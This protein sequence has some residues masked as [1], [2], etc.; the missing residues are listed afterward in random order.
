[1]PDNPQILSV[2]TSINAQKFLEA[3]S[4]SDPKLL[5]KEARSRFGADAPLILQQLE[6]LQKAKTKAPELAAHGWLFTRQ[7]YEQASSAATAR[8]KQTLMGGKQLVDLTAGAGID[9]WYLSKLFEKTLLVEANEERAALLGHNFRQVAQVEV[10]HATAEE[11]ID[12]LE[13]NVTVYI[14]PDRRPGGQRVNGLEQSMPDILALLPQLRAKKS[15]VWIK[16]SPMLDISLLRNQLGSNTNI[17]CISVDQEMKELLLHPDGNGLLEAVRL[18][19][20]GQILHRYSEDA[21]ANTQAN[22][23]AD[24]QIGDWFVEPHV[25]LI[26]SRLAR[27][28]AAQQGWKA[29]N[30]VADYYFSAEA[31]SDA[32]GRW[33]RIEKLWPYKPK[34]LPVWLKE[35]GITKANIAKRD[36]FLD[37]AALRKVLRLADGGDDYLFFTKNKNGDPLVV[38]GRRSI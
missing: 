7:S 2:L 16:A 9:G 34:L 4:F 35:T 1:M 3:Y 12:R 13:E 27:K 38:H 22:L 5:Q 19:E 18:H 25:A 6:L 24:A 17:W 28:Y 20:N 23:V 36:F 8:F 15:D 32:E 11:Q 33:F 10:V 21:E 30:Q 29:F 14:D 26:K 31:G 37:V